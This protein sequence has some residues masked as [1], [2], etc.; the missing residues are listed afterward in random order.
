MD[1]NDFMLGV[2]WDSMEFLWDSTIFCCMWLIMIS[3]NLKYD[4]NNLKESNGSNESQI[5][6]LDW[7]I[8]K[9]IVWCYIY[10]YEHIN[11]Y[12][13]CLTNLFVSSLKYP[14]LY[15]FYFK[16]SSYNYSSIYIISFS[17]SWTKDIQLHGCNSADLR[18]PINGTL[19][20]GSFTAVSE[21][22]PSAPPPSERS[23]TTHSTIVENFVA[24]DRY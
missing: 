19:L 13:L 5:L 2:L 10:M 20:C 18:T 22:W 6:N 3:N 23:P 24:R 4:S 7:S 21:R 12:L 16:I 17:Y 9:Q 8:P 11:S 14:H 1:R 15:H